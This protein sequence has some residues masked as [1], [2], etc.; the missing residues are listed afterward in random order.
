MYR[1]NLDP[2]QKRVYD[3]VKTSMLSS[4]ITPSVREIAEGTG[5]RSPS[6]VHSILRELEDLGYVKIGRGKSRRISLAGFGEKEASSRALSVPVLYEI[7][8]PDDLFNPDNAD[9]YLT[10]EP[11][12]DAAEGRRFAVRMTDDSM[13]DALLRN[14]DVLV[15]RSSSEARPGQIVVSLLSDGIY[16]SEYSLY[17]ENSVCLRK[18]DGASFG[19]IVEKDDAG[20][21]GIVEC[22]IRR[23]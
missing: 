17:G 15:A 14:G 10:Y 7:T 20:I 23:L 19:R 8:D 18:R 13:R 12:E 5:Y 4:G 22:V 16:V 1:Q 6:S 11:P 21:I 3:F 2:R 9:G